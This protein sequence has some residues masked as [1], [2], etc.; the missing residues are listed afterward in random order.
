MADLL[1][2]ATNM[3]RE[4][5]TKELYQWMESALTRVKYIHHH[6]PTKKHPYRA[7]QFPIEQD[8]FPSLQNQAKFTTN[9]LRANPDFTGFFHF[10]AKIAIVTR[11]IKPKTVYILPHPIPIDQQPQTK[12]LGG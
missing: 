12:D 10:S 9:P 4:G 3:R 8:S 1:N 7:R 5:A 2:T 6:K 11:E